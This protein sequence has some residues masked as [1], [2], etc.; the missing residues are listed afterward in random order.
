MART[1]A[2]SCRNK[3]LNYLGVGGAGDAVAEL[4]GIVEKAA[5]THGLNGFNGAAETYNQLYPPA[6]RT[7]VKDVNAAGNACRG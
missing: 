2:G 7:S 1:V 3:L 6:F 4:A 5:L